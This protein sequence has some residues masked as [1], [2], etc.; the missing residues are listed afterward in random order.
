MSADA[1]TNPPMTESKTARKKREKAEAEAAAKADVT[2]SA[3]TPA[4]EQGEPLVN[5][6]SQGE[7]AF[8][9][10]LQK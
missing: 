6:E 10:E 7:S 2:P 1:I 4:E 5:G 9:R 3:S 8:V